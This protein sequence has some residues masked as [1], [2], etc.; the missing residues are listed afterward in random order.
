M[1]PG[2]G[3]GSCRHRWGSPPKT[4]F[5]H[6]P[7]AARFCRVAGVLLGCYPE[8]PASARLCPDTANCPNWAQH[9]GWKPSPGP[10]IPPSPSHSKWL[11]SADTG[12]RQEGT[13]CLEP[14]LASS[15]GSWVVLSQN[16]GSLRLGAQP[17]AISTCRLIDTLNALGALL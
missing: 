11:S 7:E 4:P 9:G 16:V 12:A 13:L 17:A 1:W 8:G 15:H 5:L 10:H 14:V 2:K 6:K 3:E